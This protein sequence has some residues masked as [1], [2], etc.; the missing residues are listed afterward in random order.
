MLT[1]LVADDEF[2]V[3]EV[4]AMALEGEG[5]RVLKA[6]DG[7]DALR[8]LVSQQCDV[9][10]CDEKMPVMNGHQLLDAVR[11]EPRLAELP[12]IM[13]SESW[14][15]PPPDVAGATVLGKPIRLAELIDTIDVVTK[16]SKRRT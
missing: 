14:G 16:V 7:A 12:F 1:V 3:L 5:H 6:G 9:I 4:L 11:A 2:A 15:K 8:I 10:V 13:M